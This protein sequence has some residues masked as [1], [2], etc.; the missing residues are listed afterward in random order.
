MDRSLDTLDDGIL[1]LSE[2]WATFEIQC[3][4]LVETRTCNISR[5]APMNESWGS[6][7]ESGCP[8]FRK[9][10][11][12]ISGNYPTV[13]GGRTRQTAFRKAPLKTLSTAKQTVPAA[14]RATSHE[15]ALT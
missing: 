7:V 14:M 2:A 5:Y 11:H 8:E 13:P 10:G 6:P 1:A 9:R 12:S 3:F 15:A 4:Y